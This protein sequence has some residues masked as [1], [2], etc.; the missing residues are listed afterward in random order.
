MHTV[1]SETRP[2]MLLRT[3][4]APTLACAESLAGRRAGPD[5]TWWELVDPAAPEHQ[6]P[7]AVAVTRADGVEA[8]RVHVLSTGPVHNGP[9]LARLLSELLAALRR[10]EMTWV[11]MVAEEPTTRDCLR[12]DGFG[13]QAGQDPDDGDLSLLL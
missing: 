6:V 2:P 11:Q 1:P 4:P 5:E 10:T 3:V 7:A 13:P 12:A 8:V 9:L